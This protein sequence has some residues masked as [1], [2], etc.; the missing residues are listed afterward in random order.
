MF[1]SVRSFVAV[2]GRRCTCSGI[3]H[4]CSQAM[5]FHFVDG[6]TIEVLTDQ[7]L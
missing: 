7:G 6:D 5:R 4:S 2:K 3:P 1:R